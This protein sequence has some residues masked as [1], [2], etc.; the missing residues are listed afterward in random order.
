[1]STS[2]EAPALIQ[3]ACERCKT[4]F[5]LPPSS[6]KLS[7]GGKFKAMSTGIGSGVQVPRGPGRGIRRRTPPAAGQDGR[8][9]LPVLRPELPLL[10]RVPPVRLQ[11]VLEHVAAKLPDLRRQV[12]DRRG[13]AAAAVCAHRTRNPEA[14]SRRRRSCSAP[15]AAAPRPH[16]GGA[17]PRRCNARPGG[18]SSCDDG[19]WPRTH[20][21]YCLRDPQPQPVRDGRRERLH[22]AVRD[23]D[24]CGH[25]EPHRFADRHADPEPDRHSEPDGSADGR[26]RRPTRRPTSAP[27]PTIPPPKPVISCSGTRDGHVHAG[28]NALVLP[29]DRHTRRGC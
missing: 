28:I 16:R 27:A 1:M 8:R 20:A 11:R 4:R 23:A 25:R 19:P 2:P 14:R 9:G 3:Y 10:P 29:A 5:V 22:G 24:A 21:G 17:G 26:H 13:T 12:D 18:R 7:I 15:W 6:R